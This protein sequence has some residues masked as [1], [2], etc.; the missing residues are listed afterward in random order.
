MPTVTVTNM[1]K[2]NEKEGNSSRQ[3][4]NRGSLPCI[5]KS[6]KISDNFVFDHIF[7]DKGREAN[8]N[9]LYYFQ[10]YGHKILRI[11]KKIGKI[12]KKC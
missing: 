4:N 8:H 9:I 3:L 6:E 5:L 2:Q 10:K 12:K 11:A 1:K 7:F